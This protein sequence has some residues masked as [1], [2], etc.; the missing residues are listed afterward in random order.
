MYKVGATIK[1][2][3]TD[4]ILQH[5]VSALGD[6]WIIACQDIIGL[7]ILGLCLITL[8]TR[9]NKSYTK[10]MK[11]AIS[12]PDK[13]FKSAE[14]LASRLGQSRSQLYTQALSSYLEKHRNDNVTKKL[15]E[16]YSKSDSRLDPALKDLQSRSLSKDQWWNVDKFGGLI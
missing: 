13:V 1:H 6:S 15:D 9:Y 12:I 4:W 16:I 2:K 10:Y 14:A 7:A 3:L 5:I 8:A 11:T